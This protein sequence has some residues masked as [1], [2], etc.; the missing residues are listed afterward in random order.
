MMSEKNQSNQKL[1]TDLNGFQ[2][3]SSKTVVIGRPQNFEELVPKLAIRGS[4]LWL[5]VALRE[6]LAQI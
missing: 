2:N 5:F 4:F 1:R 6:F 3:F